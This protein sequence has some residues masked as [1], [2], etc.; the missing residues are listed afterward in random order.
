[1]DVSVLEKNPHLKTTFSHP[2]ESFHKLPWAFRPHSNTMGTET[3]RA[4]K[5]FESLRLCNSRQRL[6]Q[7]L[8]HRS[9]P[10]ER[11]C[12]FCRS[13]GARIAVVFSNL[14]PVL[15]TGCA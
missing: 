3:S 2:R 4:L 9:P 10:N 1:M 6:V 12:R 11:N 8:V 14:N 7:V 13:L 5:N 15:E